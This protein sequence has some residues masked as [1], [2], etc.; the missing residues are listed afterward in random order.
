[1][2]DMT[3]RDLIVYILANGLEDMP[4]CENG[5]LRGFLTPS[6]AAVVYGVGYAT[7]LV[8]IDRGQLPAMKLGDSWYIPMG[9][10]NPLE[11]RTDANNNSI[12]DDES[13]RSAYEYNLVR[14]CTAKSGR[15]RYTGRADDADRR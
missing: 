1:M 12:L 6:E 5:K 14:L 13:F 8:W 15:A 4:V 7:V 2:V 10:K 11:R 9:V 3:Y